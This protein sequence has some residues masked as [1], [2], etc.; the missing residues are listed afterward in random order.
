MVGDDDAAKTQPPLKL[1]PSSPYYLGP[2]DPRDFLTP[3]RLC[4]DNYDDWAT[5]IQN[6][7]KDRRKFYFINGRGQNL[8]SQVQRSTPVIRYA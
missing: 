5:D 3:N 2:Q 6:A 8:Y 1:D 7:L 4:A